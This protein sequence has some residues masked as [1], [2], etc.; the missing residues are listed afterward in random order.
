MVV[1]C[2]R[3]TAEPVPAL[4]RDAI[5]ASPSAMAPSVKPENP[6]PARGVTTPALD[7]E[8]AAMSVTVLFD[9]NPHN[10]RLRTAWGF[11]VLLEYR[12]HSLLFDTG[13]E[14]GALLRNMS[15][16]GLDPTAVDIVVLSHIHGDHTGGLASLL[17]MN[18]LVS[19]YVPQAFSTRFKEDVRRTGE[20]VV[21]IDAPREILPGLWST[22]QMGTSIV[23]Q[24]LVAQTEEGLVIVTGCAHPGADEMVERAQEVGQSDTTLVAGGFHLGGASL[25]RIEDMISEFQRLGVQHVAPCHCTGDKAV[26]MICQ[27]SGE[28][29]FA[30]GAGCQWQGTVSE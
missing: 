4:P 18:P 12:G 14:D 28:D 9:S 7:L 13:A 8:D 29:F 25:G 20:G 22:G 21:E 16:L 27:A 24:A 23:E 5:V 15:T 11:A 2:A 10:P 6:A 30:C 17:A 1:G 19:V 3:I 26:E